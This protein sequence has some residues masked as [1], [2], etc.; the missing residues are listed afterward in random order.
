M[1]TA[2]GRAHTP[3]RLHAATCRAA[4]DPSSLS[5]TRAEQM[6][7]LTCSDPS[8]LAASSKQHSRQ[9]PTGKPGG[10]RLVWLH[11]T[12]HRNLRRGT[13]KA[14]QRR[15]LRDRPQ[16]K[17]PRRLPLESGSQWGTS[18]RP[19]QRAVRARKP[20]GRA[21]ASLLAIQDAVGR[22]HSYRTALPAVL[23]GGK[24]ARQDICL[25]STDLSTRESQPL[26]S[27]YFSERALGETRLL[28]LGLL[29]RALA[30]AFEPCF[31]PK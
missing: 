14:G 23:A 5:E 10:V 7:N 16:R 24:T 17:S 15:D 18:V 6:E 29:A 22:L 21:G 12:I 4:P 30:R 8:S 3:F 1:Q 9:L 26:N 13:G 28:A 20:G 31:P 19:G 27:R 2:R 11:V 25:E